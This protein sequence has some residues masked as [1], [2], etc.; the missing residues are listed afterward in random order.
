MNAIS[1][2]RSLSGLHLGPLRYFD[3][4]GSTNVEA[5]HW[6]RQGA[7]DL[8]LVVADEQTSG[9]G[10]HGRRWHTPPGA[11][12]AFSLVLRPEKLPGLNLH[13]DNWEH[14]QAHLTHLAALGALAVC[15]G[16][17]AYARK[18]E[19]HIHPKIKWPNDVLVEGRKLSGVLVESH[20]EGER[21]TALILGIGINVAP[22]S[23]PPNDQLSFPASCVEEILGKAV[24]RRELLHWVLSALLNRRDQLPNEAFMLDWERRMA[25][26]GRR[27]RILQ[28]VP[29][30]DAILVEGRI[31]GLSK[32]GGLCLQVASGET[33]TIHSGEVRLRPVDRSP[34]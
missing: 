21:L 18:H 13:P 23:I 5:A 7:P 15:D 4:I 1:L 16:L 31:L 26:V 22:V 12:L 11:A 29:G 8:S 20:W 10:R 25:Y 34:K 30:H 2:Q 3:T 9:R 17:E 33:L 28:A 19:G 32:S 6:A 14:S 27:V 24:S